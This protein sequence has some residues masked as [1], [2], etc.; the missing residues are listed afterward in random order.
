MVFNKIAYLTLKTR[1]FC[2]S[3]FMGS[4]I[5][6]FFQGQTP[7]RRWSELLMSSW[8]LWGQEV[9][10]PREAMLL[11]ETAT[12]VEFPKSQLCSMILQSIA[13]T[14]HLQWQDYDHWQSSTCPESFAC[15]RLVSSPEVFLFFFFYLFVGIHLFLLCPGRTQCISFSA[16]QIKYLKEQVTEHILTLC[17][18][19]YM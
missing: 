6:H 11:L 16:Q 5:S 3:I 14:V 19:W 4:L 17:S 10:F 7:W 13:T 9:G 12:W 2:D 8:V 18:R 1:L 15:I